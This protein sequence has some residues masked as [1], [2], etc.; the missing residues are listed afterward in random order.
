M[1]GFGPGQIDLLQKRD[2]MS[3]WGNKDIDDSVRFDYAWKWFDFHADQRMK[4][5]NY[6]VIVF[7]IFA[8]G[9]VTAIDKG[10]AD[11][12]AILCLIA[13]SLAIIFSRLDSRNQ[14]L[15]SL[16]EDVLAELEK[17]RIFVGFPPIQ[18][19]RDPT[20]APVK[21]AI[22]WRE[23]EEERPPANQ[24]YYDQWWQDAWA[25]KHRFW[26]RKI[27]FILALLFFASASGIWHFRAGIDARAPKPDAA[28][29]ATPDTASKQGNASPI[30]VV[31]PIQMIAPQ[32][33]APAVSSGA[34]NLHQPG[35]DSNKRLDNPAP[36]K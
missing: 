7:G 33:T 25:G 23:R 28:A 12:A 20:N 3:D 21:Y 36:G 9:V 14:R 15:L 26:M 35:G 13:G 30:T 16:G 27:A 10:L 29:T 4:M 32:P 34:A 5:F 19:D 17:T 11:V 6:Q 24:P 18:T 1:W 31:A 8:T 2:N 22:L